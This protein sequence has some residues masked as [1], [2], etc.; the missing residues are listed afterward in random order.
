MPSGAEFGVVTGISLISSVTGLIIPILSPG[1]GYSVNQ[2]LPSGS[3]VIPAG[4]EPA[5]GTLQSVIAFV[6]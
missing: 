3:D 4:C 2:R 6:G 5:V 1:S